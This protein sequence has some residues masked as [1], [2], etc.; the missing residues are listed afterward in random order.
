MTLANR[1]LPPKVKGRVVEGK[2]RR[3][4]FPGQSWWVGWRERGRPAGG[5]F[6]ERT[7]YSMQ[8]SAPGAAGG[9]APADT[10][11]VASKLET[12]RMGAVLPSGERATP[13]SCSRAPGYVGLQGDERRILAAYRVLVAA[14][15][16]AQRP[17]DLPF[18]LTCQSE[19]PDACADARR[20]LATLPMEA[21][22]AVWTKCTEA[23]RVVDDHTPGL[24]LI[25]CRPLEPG[26]PYEAEVAFGMSGDDG[27]S[28]RIQ[29]IHADRWPA[30]IALRRSMIIYH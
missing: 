9:D 28:W 1:L 19:K 8:L 24:R 12:W 13:D 3:Q 5:D 4:F 18:A 16:A 29:F 20:A 14:M 25:G 15:A 26:Q 30:T 22:S 6:C 27:Q 23:D 17:G 2:I 7:A 11:L 10:L 21:L